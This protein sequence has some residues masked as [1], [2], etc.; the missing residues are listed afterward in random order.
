MS[1]IPSIITNHGEEM[2]KWTDER[3]R[4]GSKIPLII[5]NSVY[6]SVMIQTAIK[7]SFIHTLSSSH[8]GQGNKLVENKVALYAFYKS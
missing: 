5:P 7:A 2:G 6:F 8:L 4:C 3:W 1:R